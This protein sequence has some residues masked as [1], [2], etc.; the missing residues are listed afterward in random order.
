MN[1]PRRTFLKSVLAGTTLALLSKTAFADWAKG[2][3]ASSSDEARKAV[4]GD[5]S[6]EDSDKID[7]NAPEVAE[8]GK[9]V[10]V[11]VSVD[12]PNVE[13]ITVIADKNPKPL[14]AQFNVQ[15]SMVEP[16][17]KTQIKMKETSDIVV[18]VKADGKLY[19]ATK[20]VEVTSGGCGG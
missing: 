20:P 5:V 16:Y 15:N 3:E 18:I 9:K 13:S 11:T 8:N 14:I 10:P 6:V 4:L 2:L 19:K 17:F 1:I 12:M 7:I